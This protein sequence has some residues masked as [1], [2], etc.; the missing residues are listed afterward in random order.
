MLTPLARG[1]ILP[2]GGPPFGKLRAGLSRTVRV[3]NSGGTPCPP[4]RRAAEKVPA[5]TAEAAETAEFL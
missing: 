5:C 2:G 4:C 1:G 3:L